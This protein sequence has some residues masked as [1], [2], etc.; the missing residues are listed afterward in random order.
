M[1]G[2]YLT[3]KCFLNTQTFAEFETV[4]LSS[5]V[6]HHKVLLKPLGDWSHIPNGYQNP[7]LP[8]TKKKSHFSPPVLE[9]E[10]RTLQLLG[11]Y[12]TT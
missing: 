4:T 10:L 6:V 5:L 9:F 7:G 1:N 12:S 2:K 8:Y 11:R 3:K